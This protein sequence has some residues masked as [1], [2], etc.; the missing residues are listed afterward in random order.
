MLWLHIWTK[1]ITAC[2]HIVMEYQHSSHKAPNPVCDAGWQFLALVSDECT[3]TLSF[4]PNWWRHCMACWAPMNDSVQFK[5]LSERVP[6]NN[7]YSACLS[8]HTCGSEYCLNVHSEG[9]VGSYECHTTG[10]SGYMI[11]VLY[12]HVYRRQDCGVAKK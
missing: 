6:I 4:E 2:S 8:E 1:Q 12:Y 7:E 5:R 10:L 11:Q 9:N 3:I